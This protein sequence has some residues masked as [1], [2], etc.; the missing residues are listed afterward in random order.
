MSC[1]SATG[2]EEKFEFYIFQDD[3]YEDEENSQDLK[4]LNTDP[5]EAETHDNQYR[6]INRKELYD[7]EKG[8]EANDMEVI[9][10]EHQQQQQIND[11]KNNY[12]N[13]QS[14]ATFGDE[15]VDD[16]LALANDD[17][18][19]V[20]TANLLLSEHQPNFVDFDEFNICLNNILNVD[21]DSQLEL[22]PSVVISDTLTTAE[23]D[24]LFKVNMDVKN[25]S[26]NQMSTTTS[27]KKTISSINSSSSTSNSICSSS[28]NNFPNLQI[29]LFNHHTAN[30]ENEE[31]L[32]NMV[33]FD[34]HMDFSFS[35]EFE[36]NTTNSSLNATNNTTNVTT[37][38]NN[39]FKYHENSITP[40]HSLTHHGNSHINDKNTTHNIDNNDDLDFNMMVDPINIQ[41]TCNPT[42]TVSAPLTTTAATSN[43]NIHHDVD[44]DDNDTQQETALNNVIKRKSHSIVNIFQ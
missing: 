31:D 3:D 8:K 33:Q 12:N 17:A 15:P 16:L 4:K 39:A 20:E 18:T 29:S 30:D 42:A 22:S 41:S 19:A 2:S 38:S 43:I 37:F 24:E 5:S 40:R 7:N 13:Y 10:K 35:S 6:T 11:M 25:K 21:V 28:K 36:R 9:N 44:K 32:L 1:A 27:N 14:I 23:V 26:L 34:D